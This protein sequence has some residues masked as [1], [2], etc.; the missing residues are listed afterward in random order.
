M[1][2]T[3]DRSEEA[4]MGEAKTKQR[5]KVDIVNSASRCVY[6]SNPPT[7]VEHMPPIWMFKG[8]QRPNGMEFACCSNCNNGTAEADLVA[9][10]ISRFSPQDVNIDTDTKFIEAYGRIEMVNQRAP[11]ILDELFSEKDRIMWERNS[12]GVLT[13]KVVIQPDGPHLKAYLDV[14]SAKMGMALYQKYVGEPLPQ[15]GAVDVRWFLNAGL[16]RET[17]NQLLRMLPGYSSLRQD[18]RDDDQFSYRYNTDCRSIVASLVKFHLGLSIFTIATSEP[19]KYPL[20]FFGSHGEVIRPGELV[21]RMPKS[22]TI[23]KQMMK[24]N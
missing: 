24:S 22:K 16:G 14:F 7:S 9:G 8:R 21:S 19:E 11:T 18:G 3:Y 2:A 5:K 4:I 15:T 10:F 23:S 20:P 17:A 13:K 1:T 12:K 6:C